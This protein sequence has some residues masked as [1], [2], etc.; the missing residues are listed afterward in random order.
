MPFFRAPFSPSLA[1]LTPNYGSKAVN[2]KDNN[3]LFFGGGCNKFRDSVVIYNVPKNSYQKFALNKEQFNFDYTGSYVEENQF[4]GLA[5]FDMA[6]IERN[7]T[8]LIYGGITGDYGFSDTLY[9]LE[10]YAELKIIQTIGDIPSPRIGHTFTK[11]NDS[12]ILLFGG[13]ENTCTMRYEMIPKY[14]NDIYILHIDEDYYRWE[15]IKEQNFEEPCPRESHTSILYKNQLIVYGG[16]NG[17][18]RL[19]DIWMLDLDS[20]SW[21]KLTTTGTIPLARSMHTATLVDNEMYIFGG[22]VHEKSKSWKCTSSIQ[23]L[24]LESYKWKNFPTGNKPNPRAGHAAIE[25][26]GR[27]HIWSGRDDNEFDETLPIKCHNDLWYFETKKPLKVTDVNVIKCDRKSFTLE[28]SAS[29]NA[30]LYVIELKEFWESKVEFK[31]EPMIVE[32]EEIVIIQD[33]PTNIVVEKAE[34]H[35]TVT[36]KKP[37]I[38]IHENILLTPP[39]TIDT[40]HLF[41]DSSSERYEI[42]NLV[43]DNQ[44]INIDQ[45]D[46]VSELAESESTDSELETYLASLSKD[47]NI[48][49]NCWYLV[50]IFKNNFCKIKNYNSHILNK[51]TLKADCIP[52]L[53]GSKLV[54][55]EPNRTYFVRVGALNSIGL[56]DMS[57]PV[58]V[59]TKQDEPIYNLELMSFN[60]YYTL[61]WN[62]TFADVEFLVS[63]D[64]KTEQYSNSVTIYKGIDCQCDI[65]KKLLENTI[66]SN[67][68]TMSIRA[69][70]PDG[71]IL[72]GTELQCSL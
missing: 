63:F 67:E 43:P 28:W 37:K 64:I 15:K 57:D 36:S 19:N 11:I 31:D 46:G 12:E 42:V 72:H 62:T 39:Y 9:V 25:Y 22:F 66:M 7:D 51:L 54:S 68:F 2:I 4:S 14:L 40:D 24:D 26:F 41:N 44:T 27:I 3:V 18:R 16:M 49:K 23:C 48:R 69:I 38:I 30:V 17:K 52:N 10:N 53:I 60:D 56:S 32:Q 6:Y 50:G 29:T 59:K 45:M 55:I 71:Q 70:A 20:F 58:T 34:K 33:H 21:I 5:A 47:K 35:E 8:V 61:K 65:S 13:V 1:F